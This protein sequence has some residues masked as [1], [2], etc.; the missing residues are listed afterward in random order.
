MGSGHQIVVQMHGEPGSG[1]ST[2]AQA[3]GAR[4]G[5]VVI[6]KDVIKASLLRVGIVE[7]QAAASAYEVFFAQALAE[8]GI[9]AGELQRADEI[10]GGLHPARCALRLGEPELRQL[11]L[12]ARDSDPRVSAAGVAVGDLDEARG[13]GRAS[14][15]ELA[16]IPLDA[17]RD[18]VARRRGL[19]EHSAAECVAQADE[20][21]LRDG[22]ARR[23][24]VT[25][26]EKA[27]R[28]RQH[29][30]R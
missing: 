15:L 22:F 11:R 20:I 5:A 7:Q 4:L 25:A 13:C 24:V 27:E 6:D 14:D 10:C 16:Q 2:V 1:K 30:C 18:V 23:A 9:E 26:E 28:L 21:F 12:E 29:E 8:H 3:L 19:A 17:L